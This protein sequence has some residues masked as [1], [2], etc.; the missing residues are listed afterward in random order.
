[1]VNAKLAVIFLAGFV[2]AASPR[3]EENAHSAECPAGFGTGL[4]QVP[5]FA[6]LSSSPFPKPPVVART[7]WG[8]PDG[9]GSRWN[10]Q[11]TTVTHL[12]VHHSAGASTS[13]DWPATVRAIWDFHT[14]PVSQGGRGWGDMGYN[15]LIDPN[16]VIYE[17]RAG[18][19]NAIGAHFS[20]RNGGTM[21][22]CLLGNFQNSSPTPAALNS[23]ARLLAWKAAQRSLSPTESAFHSATGSTLLSVCGHRDANAFYPEE[24]CT[25]TTCP[26]DGLYALLPNL[27]L[28]VQ[29]LIEAAAMAPQLAPLPPL[30][31]TSSGA[32][33]LAR[34]EAAAGNPVLERRFEWGTAGALT[35]WTTSVLVQG[36]MVSAGVG[37]LA[38]DSDYQFR[39]SA[40]TSAG[41]TTSE[42]LSFR[43]RTKVAI[44]AASSNPLLEVLGQPGSAVMIQGST[45]LVFWTPLQNGVIG[46]TGSLKLQL[47][48][49]AS[50]QYFRVFR[51]D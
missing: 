30:E 47:H 7:D 9:Q 4:H 23:L 17:G 8:S 49:A 27:R 20:C 45:N 15:Y 22:A 42:P 10:P 24:A 29:T 46:T 25:T 43:T 41:W 6:I 48:P 38:I 1:M 40:R 51:I 14:R 44:Q 32:R 18:G 50:R 28:E 12:V 26:G 37:N 3:A 19:D 39:I 21:G 34:V 33:L 35:R 36:D 2:F 11:Y 5:D 13:A 16:G 31:I